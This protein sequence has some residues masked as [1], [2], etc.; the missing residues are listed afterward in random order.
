MEDNTM[1]KQ[2]REAMISL[3]DKTMEE[4]LVTDE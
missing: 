1:L 2:R 3:L 4:F